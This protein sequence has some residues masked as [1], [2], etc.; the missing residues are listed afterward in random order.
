[1]SLEV[2]GPRDLSPLEKAAIYTV[3]GGVR[4]IELEQY[5]PVIS[6][7]EL[8][9]EVVPSV[10]GLKE[11]LEGA[12][13]WGAA[14][15]VEVDSTYHINDT[16]GKGII[17]MSRSA[18][19][20]TD[21]LHGDSRPSKRKNLTPANI[22]YLST[23]VY[24]CTRYWQWK[25]GARDTPVRDSGPAYH[26]TKKQLKEKT[27]PDLKAE[28]HAS[29]TQVYFVIA[30]S[31]NH[32]P[33]RWI[34]RNGKEER[35]FDDVNLTGGPPDSEHSVGPVDR[36]ERIADIPYKDGRRMVSYTLAESLEHDF[37]SHISAL[38]NVGSKKP[39]VCAKA[40]QEA[41]I[42]PRSRFF[43]PRTD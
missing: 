18:F 24:Q 27:R 25:Y 42:D 34:E 8:Q 21:N 23:F 7:L 35:E 40:M 14:R 1:M 31:I 38:K 4:T 2:Q 19:P 22:H 28:R 30:W 32:T 9:L 16:N 20:R 12:T 39:L 43:K 11:G 36:Y 29:A 13:T 41:R 33:W 15:Q 5:E 3:F 6:P 37:E 26:F 10:G 17:T